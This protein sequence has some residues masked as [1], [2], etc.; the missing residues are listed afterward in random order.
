M[1]DKELL[2][3]AL[4]IELAHAIAWLKANSCCLNLDV[5]AAY[6]WSDRDHELYLDLGFVAFH[7]LGTLEAC[8]S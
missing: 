3:M 5:A 4:T 6:F 8:Q 1:L 7:H 2:L